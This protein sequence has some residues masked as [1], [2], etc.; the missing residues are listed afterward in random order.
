MSEKNIALLKETLSIMNRGYYYSDEAKV[1]LQLTKAQMQQAYVILPDEIQQMGKSK[2]RRTIYNQGRCSIE[3]LKMDSLSA[4]R[5][6]Y[7]DYM[8]TFT[9]SDKPVLVLNFA[10]PLKPGGGV[11]TGAKSQEQDLCHKSSLLLSLESDPS[12]KFY[13]YHHNLRTYLASDAMIISP[14]VEIIRDENDELLKNMTDTVAVLTCSA[15]MVTDDLYGMSNEQYQDI[16]FQRI[17]NIFKCAAH[18]GYDH[19]VLGAWGCG[20]FGNDPE[21]VAGLFYKAMIESIYDGK[22]IFE[23]F[24]KIDFAVLDKTPSKQLYRIFRRY[25]TSENFYKYLKTERDTVELDKL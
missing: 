10:S 7:K 25:F 16:L 21:V 17:A 9:H 20:A 11:W 24:R 13:N 15:P 4:A 5:R 19:L 22:R 3:C 6:Q 23:L 12:K 1:T 2:I 8:Q 14:Q 18:F